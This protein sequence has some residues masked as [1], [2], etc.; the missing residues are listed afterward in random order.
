MFC[1]NGTAAS[2]KL[3]LSNCHSS[4]NEY[5]AA[6]ALIFI[7]CCNKLIFNEILYNS[8]N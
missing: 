2:K 6:K 5:H 4:L 3:F 7:I 1:L 8:G